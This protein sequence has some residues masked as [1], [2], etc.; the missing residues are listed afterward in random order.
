MHSEKP[1][2]KIDAKELLIQ[3]LTSIIAGVVEAICK[4]FNI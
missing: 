2:S 4:F 1:N 3:F